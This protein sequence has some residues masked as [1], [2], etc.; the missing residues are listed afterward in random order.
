MEATEAL[1]GFCPNMDDLMMTTMSHEGVATLTEERRR[2][3]HSSELSGRE[4]SRSNLAWLGIGHRAMARKAEAIDDFTGLCEF[5][6]LPLKSY[7]SGM[8]ARPAF[9][10]ATAVKPRFLLSDQT[11][12]VG[13]AEFGLKARACVFD[14]TNIAVIVSRDLSC[15]SGLWTQ[16][17]GMW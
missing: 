2:R 7:S 10:S 1:I 4:N 3:V 11:P 15:L 6:D 5:Y 13:D 8:Y 9:G 16:G 17:L 12:G 14:R